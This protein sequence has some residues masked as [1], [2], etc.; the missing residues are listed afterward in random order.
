MLLSP[1]GQRDSSFGEDHGWLFAF[2]WLRSSACLGQPQLSHGGKC[3]QSS[4]CPCSPGMRDTPGTAECQIANPDQAPWGAR[5]GAEPS[6][7]VQLPRVT[8][9]QLD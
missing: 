5:D 6:K 3:S 4:C 2:L 8:Q 7:P 9:Q 1:T